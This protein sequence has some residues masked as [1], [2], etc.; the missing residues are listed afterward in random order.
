MRQH[1]HGSISLS[2]VV[3]LALVGLALVPADARTG[4]AGAIRVVPLVNAE[5]GDSPDLVRV[6]A[7]PQ[8]F[9]RGSRF[10]AK[11]TVTGGA[12]RRTPTRPGTYRYLCT[13]HPEMRGEIIV[14][15]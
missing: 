15:R 10:Q 1:H 9:A 12:F 4:T 13:I 11:E 8:S 7:Y 3:A 2:A 14:D 6:I 5:V